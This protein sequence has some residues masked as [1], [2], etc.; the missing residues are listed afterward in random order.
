MLILLLLVTAVPPTLAASQNDKQTAS[1]ETIKTQ[2]AKLGVGE[3]AKATIKLRDGRK[4]K[5]YIARAGDDDFVI[6]DRKTDSPNTILYADVA[7]V[8]SNRGHSTARDVGIG[9]GLG[10]GAAI[11]LVIF[12]L[13]RG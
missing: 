1:P 6:R 3:K 2:I 7:K 8:E 13:A 11:G 5:G 10:A 9:V 12:L 4:V